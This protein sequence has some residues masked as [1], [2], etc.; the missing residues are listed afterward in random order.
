MIKKILYPLIGLLVFSACK[1]SKDYL[2]RPDEDKTLYDVVKA[3]S[4][5]PNDSNALKSL[6]VLYPLAEQR[7]LNKINTYNT[8][9]E[10]AR[11]D[12]VI[13]EYGI[14]QKMYEAISN[15]GTASRLVKATNYQQSISGSKQL[16]AEEYYQEANVFLTKPGRDDAKKAYTYFKKAD[17]WIPGYKDAKAKMEEAYQNAIVNVIINPVQDNS[18]FFNTGWGNTGYDYSNEYFQQTLV[19]ELGGTNSSRYPAKFYTEWEARRDNVNPDWVVELTLRNLDIPRPTNYTYSHNASQQIEV[20]RDSSGHPTY[21]T[22][23]ATVFITRQSFTARGELQV[24]ITDVLTR[25][26]ISTNIYRD[27]YSWQE[28]HASY[29][30]DS[31]ALNGSDLALVNNNRFNEPNKEEVLSELYRRIYPQVKNGISYAVDW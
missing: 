11:W 17:K 2:S 8:Y 18:F 29:N 12:K 31:R 24:E 23:S 6:P 25:K 7:H 20:D 13:D 16:A 4:K 15:D 10:V 9:K 19:R 30:G 21:Q 28:E 22:V 3:L 26:I 14:L 5:H 1:T 27:D